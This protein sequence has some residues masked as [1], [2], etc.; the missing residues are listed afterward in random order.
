MVFCFLPDAR[1]LVNQAE[2]AQGW[3]NMAVRAAIS[4]G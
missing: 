3:R 1:M 2:A 4:S